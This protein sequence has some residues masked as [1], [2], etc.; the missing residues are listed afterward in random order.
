MHAWVQ[1][2]ISGNAPATK[3]TITIHVPCAY[4]NGNSCDQAVA[5]PCTRLHYNPLM[6][7]ARHNEL[8]GIELLQSAPH[9]QEQGPCLQYPTAF[10]NGNNGTHSKQ[11]ALT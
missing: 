10:P 4:S 6:S 3:A 5:R 9:M 1:A 7:G 11:P 2:G 8:D